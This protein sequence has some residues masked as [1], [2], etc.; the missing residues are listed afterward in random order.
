MT[1]SPIDQDPEVPEI[2]N[3]SGAGVLSNRDALNRTIRR[4]FIV[5]FVQSNPVTQSLG[6]PMSGLRSRIH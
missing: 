1:I 3:E 4:N 2:L 6:R 5:S